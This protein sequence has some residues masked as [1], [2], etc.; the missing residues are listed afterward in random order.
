MKRCP[1][2]KVNYSSLLLAEDAL[3][4][5]WIRNHYTIGQGPVNVY[6]CTYCEEFHFTSK[7]EMNVRLREALDIGTIVRGRRAFDFENR[8]KRR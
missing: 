1:S 4:E 5:T 8:L 3:L 7:G 2:G 6:Q